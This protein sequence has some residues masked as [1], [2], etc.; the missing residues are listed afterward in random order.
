M[1]GES[2]T[3][4]CKIW[5]KSSFAFI[6]V[7][8]IKFS[9]T[10]LKLPLEMHEFSFFLVFFTLTSQTTKNR[11]A[12]FSWLFSYGTYNYVL[13]IT[14]FVHFRNSRILI[15]MSLIGVKISVTIY[16]K[17]KYSYVFKH[18]MSLMVV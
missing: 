13:Q 4:I 6:Q 17:R 1:E 14:R 9:D 7:G 11:T 10:F 15:N 12:T 8:S 3:F 2:K 18:E 5:D 16:T